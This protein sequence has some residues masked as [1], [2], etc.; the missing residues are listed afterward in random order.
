MSKFS[1]TDEISTV[2]KSYHRISRLEGAF[3]VEASSRSLLIASQQGLAQLLFR[4]WE[5]V[6]LPGLWELMDGKEEH[7]RGLQL[8]KD[9][10]VCLEP[11]QSVCLNDSKYG[12]KPEAGTVGIS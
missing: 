5:W 2:I 6:Q 3:K 7:T 12:V 4:N 1:L 8:G 11:A 9:K 10:M